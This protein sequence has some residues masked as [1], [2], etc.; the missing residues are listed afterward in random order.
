MEVYDPC[1]GTGGM[2]IEAYYYLKS[3]DGDPKKLFL[4]VNP[5]KS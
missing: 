3:C 1:C 2:L 5:S 4:F